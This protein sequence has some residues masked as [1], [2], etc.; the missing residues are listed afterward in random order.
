M[1]SSTLAPVA[2]WASM[3]SAQMM[4]SVAVES[5]ICDWNSIAD[6]S[7]SAHPKH[8]YNTSID[9]SSLLAIMRK[10]SVAMPKRP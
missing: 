5:G 1:T 7:S 10:D 6:T 2:A 9:I 3:R 4:T 8:S